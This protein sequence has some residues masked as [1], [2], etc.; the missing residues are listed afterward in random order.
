[1]ALFL[2]AFVAMLAAG[3]GVMET[4]K[5][6]T[7]SAA[8]FCNIA[9]VFFFFLFAVTITAQELINTT[10]GVNEFLLA[11][12]EW[13]RRTC[14]FKLNQRISFAIEFDSFL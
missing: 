2:L 7:M 5:T 3:A 12:E 4:K 1:M 11:G 9:V 10:C 6:A 14:D 8:A 13:V